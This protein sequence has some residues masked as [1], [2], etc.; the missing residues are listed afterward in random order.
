MK[1]QDIYI[2]YSEHWERSVKSDAQGFITYFNVSSPMYDL[3]L[4]KKIKF[5]IWKK[6]TNVTN[7]DL[8]PMQ[9]YPLHHP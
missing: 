4:K 9:W 2:K 3:S 1:V 8:S 6:L 5:Y 7:T